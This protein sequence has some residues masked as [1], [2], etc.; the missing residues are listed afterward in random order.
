MKIPN[1]QSVSSWTSLDFLLN[2]YL[3]HHSPVSLNALP[4]SLYI[5]VISPTHKRGLQQHYLYLHELPQTANDG[6][7]FPFMR[8]WWATKPHFQANMHGSR[9]IYEN[10]FRPSAGTG[11]P[12]SIYVI[13]IIGFYD[14][15]HSSN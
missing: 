10:T 2:S 13:S 11:F 8:P 12:R 4:W 15:K 5:N 9:Q 7:Q 6:L 3:L 14:K 1:A